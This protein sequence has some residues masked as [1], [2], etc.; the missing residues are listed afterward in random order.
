M[1]RVLLLATGNPSRG[2]DAMGPMLA[3][4][5]A[6]GAQGWPHLTLTSITDFQL[7]IEHTLDMRT[8]D[9][10][11]C[12]DAEVGLPGSLRLTEIRPRRDASFS[13]HLLSPVAL[14]QIYCETQE[15][16]PPAMFALGISAY[17]FALGS[18]PGPAAQ[19]NLA[20]AEDLVARLLDVPDVAA[21]RTFVCC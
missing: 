12:L 7:Q 18:S 6:T 19:A 5:V 1:T 14:L 16:R 20:V 11:L 4:R 2:D 17:Q 3:H 21:W 10:V 9:L 13:S 8:Q 15:C